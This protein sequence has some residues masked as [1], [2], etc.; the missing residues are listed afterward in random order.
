MRL[1]RKRMAG[2]RGARAQ[3]HDAQNK[4][5]I[6][7][8]GFQPRWRITSAGVSPARGLRPARPPGASSPAHAVALPFWR[9]R[10]QPCCQGL[11]APP[12]DHFRRSA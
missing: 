3:Q 10:C 4:S 9:I 6:N 5:M 11:R 7:F 12:K 1:S 8:A 2:D